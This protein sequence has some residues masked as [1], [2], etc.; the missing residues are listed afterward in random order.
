MVFYFAPHTNS[1]RQVNYACLQCKS[2]MKLKLISQ[3]KD[4]KLFII[5]LTNYRYKCNDFNI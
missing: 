2:Y 1:S 5:N 4:R 3:I